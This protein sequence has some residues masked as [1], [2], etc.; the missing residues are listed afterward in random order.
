MSIK[1]II[2][3]I[4]LGNKC[5]SD[6]YIKYLRKIGMT[7]GEGTNIFAPNHSFIDDTRPFLIEIGKNV[8]ITYG[9]TI[10]THGYDWSVIKGVYGDVLGSAGKVI[11]GN[12]VF[13]GVNSTILKGVRVG[14]N[15]IIGA[16][17]IVNKDIPSNSVAVGNP[18]KVIMSL[19]EY[20]EKRKNIQ[21]L[22]AEEL[23]KSYRNK[24]GC[25]P[26][27]NELSEFFWIFTDSH[28]KLENCWEEK[29]KLVGNYEHSY[30]KLKVNKKIYKNY[31]EFLES[32]GK[33][34]FNVRED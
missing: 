16:G 24:F 5:D 29:M 20:Y 14:D 2:R 31:I 27:K 15:V 23:V 7:I 28:D 3:K 11:I 9:V 18:A 6:S 34:N 17:S 1:S 8:Q 13:I 26:K 33:D 21:L 10:L 19:D 22:E 12:N 4:I 32:V 30:N 25:D